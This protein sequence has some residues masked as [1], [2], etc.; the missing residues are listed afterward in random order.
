[1]AE[2][3]IDWRDVIGAIRPFTVELW[4]SLDLSERRRFLR[5]MQAHWD[6]HRHRTA[7]QPH[8]VLQQLLK[9]GRLTVQAGRLQGMKLLDH[10]RVKVSWRP[11]HQQQEQHLEVGTVI[12]CTGP[13]NQVT[14]STDPLLASLL[15]QGLVVPDALGLGVQVDKL[16]A[17]LDRENR[18]SERLFYTG[19]LLKARDWECTA[20]PELRVA[21]LKLADRLAR[22]AQVRRT[23]EAEV[24]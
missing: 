19:P 2:Q 4:Q 24:V 16:G 23:A 3:G 13:Q 9:E 15:R 22:V 11:R 7:P 6:S 21:A 5:H 14:R 8:A 20:V 17:L 1:L 12:N 10:T 18:V